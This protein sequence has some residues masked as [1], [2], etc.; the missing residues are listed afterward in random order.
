[1]SDAIRPER[2]R[3][4]FLSL[5]ETYSP[6]G[7]EESVL[8][9]LEDFFAR[10]KCPYGIQPVDEERYNLVLGWPDAPL[11]FV[12][13]VDTVDVWD[14]EDIGPEDLG[15]GWVRGLG[16]VDMKGAVPPWSRRTSHCAVTAWVG[17]SA[18]HC[19][20]ARR[21]RETAPRP[22]CRRRVLEGPWWGNLRIFVSAQATTATSR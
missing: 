18:W 5:V 4:L 15:D 14:L 6:S 7:K 20:S 2:L 11:V 13:H 19:S 21:K 3:E 10:E 17:S 12:G 16:A 9:Y 8:A 1:M 22:S